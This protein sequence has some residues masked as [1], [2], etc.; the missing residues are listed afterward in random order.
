MPSFIALAILALVLF[1][2]VN[3]YFNFHRNLNRAKRSGIPYVVVPVYYLNRWWMITHRLYLPLLAKLPRRWTGWVDFCVPD[4]DYRCSIEIFQRVGHD[5]FLTVAPG[6]MMLHTSEPAVINQITTRRNDFPKP[7]AIYRSL[8]IYGKNV[9]STEGTLWRQHRKATSPP[10]TEKNNHLVWAESIDQASDMLATWVGPDGKGDFTVD[11]VMDDTMRLSL[12]VI[13]RA[14][15]GRKL[16]W[17]SANAKADIDANY[18]DNSKIQNQRDGRDPG[19][20]MS[21]TY[22]IHCLLDNILLQFLIP[23]WLM[24]RIPSKI[25][26]KA[27][28][29]YFEWGNYMKEAVASKKES[30]EAGD[31]SKD[32]MD[33]LGQL[34]KGQ[35]ASQKGKDV[36]LTDPEILGNMFVIILA[37]HE[38]A[39]NS[40]HFSL[41]YLA[42]FPESQRAVQ[43]DLDRIFQGRPPSEW[44]YDRD[45]PALFGGMVGA[46]LAEELRLVPPVI[47]IPKSTWGVEDQPLTVEG[48]PCTVPS[49]TYVIL[50]TSNVHRNPKYWP[51]GKPTL[52]GG[53]P[54]HPLA[55]IDND[56]EE[57][58]PQRWLLD[59]DGAIQTTSATGK[60]DMPSEAVTAD[61]LGVNE[62]SDTSERLYRP[63]KGSYLPFSDGYRACLG[64]RFAQVEV[65]ATL[66]VILQNYSVELAVDQWASDEEVIAMDEDAR[67]EVWQKAANR[68][69]EMMLNGLS[70]IISLQMRKGHVSMRF[71]PRGTEK[72]MDDVDEKWKQKHPDLCLGMKAV[73]DWRFWD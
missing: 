43:R 10:F 55:N 67:V 9:V 30:L 21:Y 66:A 70:V 61:G 52:P 36:P 31:E 1:P 41:V 25:F 23:R 32:Q 34:V 39:A 48:K 35:V 44:D 26:K 24:E 28:E 12:H 57:F 47:G 2:I 33:I 5:T 59:E 65:L 13:S 8:D 46:V 38:T 14:G 7:T 53:K 69:R 56:L 72:F 3:T 51:T 42:L 17:P 40:I 22:A 4:F 58:R 49:G 45:L 15:F 64:R 54:V 68:A 16:Q 11:R 62:A 6:G 37:G 63:P 73:P 19:H 29:A 27:N 20:S 71:V 50:S 18:V 60:K